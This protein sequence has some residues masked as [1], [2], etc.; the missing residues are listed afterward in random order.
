MSSSPPPF[1]D[2]KL[3]EE[4][5]AHLSDDDDDNDEGNDSDR[6]S[7]Q[8]LP[9][10]CDLEDVVC[11]RYMIPK[12]TPTPKEEMLVCLHLSEFNEIMMELEDSIDAIN[13]PISRHEKRFKRYE[14]YERIQQ[15]QQQQQPES[16]SRAAKRKKKKKSPMVPPTPITDKDRAT[17]EKLLKQLAILLQK[18]SRIENY[19]STILLK[20]IDA[21]PKPTKALSSIRSLLERDKNTIHSIMLHLDHFAYIDSELEDGSSL[22]DDSSEYSSDL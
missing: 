17:H 10:L 21:H 2:G 18:K 4:E 20:T 14:N 13:E 19:Y 1:Y 11:S 16:T 7:I 9:E 5:V 22:E 12:N 8:S 6:G 3:E 15:Q